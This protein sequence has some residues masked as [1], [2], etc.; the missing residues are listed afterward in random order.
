MNAPMQPRASATNPFDLTG[1]RA[2]GLVVTEAENGRLL[3]L[4]TL[5]LGSALFPLKP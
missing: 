4:P 1:R 5:G 3:S 2:L